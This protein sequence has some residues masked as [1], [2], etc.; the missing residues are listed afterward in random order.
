[1]KEIAQASVL[2]E[3]VVEPNAKDKELPGDAPGNPGG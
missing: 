3:H 2:K 1:M